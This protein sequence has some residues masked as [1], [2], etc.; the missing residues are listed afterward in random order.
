MAEAANSDSTD[1]PFPAPPRFDATPTPSLPSTIGDFDSLITESPPSSQARP[2]HSTGLASEVIPSPM[3]S[4]G[5]ENFL[6][7]TNNE[8]DESDNTSSDFGNY[9]DE[10]YDAERE[11]DFFHRQDS[12]EEGLFVNNHNNG[13]SSIPRD[14]SSASPM[15]QRSSPEDDLFMEEQF[16]AA[17]EPGHDAADQGD[18]LVEI[19][20]AEPGSPRDHRGH[21]RRPPRAQPQVIDLTG[22]NDSSPANSSPRHRPHNERRLRPQ[23]R[24]TPP[25]LARSDA[26]YMGTRTVIDLVSDSDDE[27]VV[28]PPLRNNPARPAVPVQPPPEQPQAGHIQ[29]GPFDPEPMNFQV[30]PNALQHIHNIFQNLPLFGLINNGPLMGDNRDEEDIVMLG[31]RNVVPN[32]APLAPLAPLPDLPQI[33]LDYIAHPFDNP[34]MLGGPN[35]K[36]VH[37]PPKEARPGFTRTT[38][39]DVVAICPSCEQELA[40]NPDG[41]D[42]NSMHPPKKVRTKKDKAEHHFWAVKAC[43]HV[44]CKKCFDHRRSTAKN[45]V[46]V[47]FRPDP[48]GVAKNK[49]LCAVEDCDTDVSG[50]AAWVGIFM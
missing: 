49:V 36:P 37:E 20:V 1:S 35:A 15:S 16:L 32:N 6:H 4:S 41:D 19:Q 22:D 44:Y 33:H 25:R 12:E 9:L 28:M 45:P 5:S 48:N 31:H 23:Q 14:L 46:P 30:S 43:G 11:L 29:R 21:G 13:A 38:G 2:R 47:G 8:G 27:P 50:K 18:E 39:E 40:Y 7:L 3:S 26:S 42:S 17:V 34:A 24:G 10:I